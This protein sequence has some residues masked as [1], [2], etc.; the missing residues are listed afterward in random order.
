[1]KE[2][3]TTGIWQT[4]QA[5]DLI[6]KYYR[7][8]IQVYHPKSNKIETFTTTEPYS[9][10]LSTNSK[11]SHIIDLSIPENMPVG[12]HQQKDVKVAAPED[13]IFYETHI[14]DFSAHDKA[15]ISEKN[16]DK[17]LAFTEQNSD[18]INHLKALKNAGINNIHL[19]PSFD[20]ATVNENES[21]VLDIN[22]PLGKLC[23]QLPTLS[24]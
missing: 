15:F 7:Y 1:M 19:L 14:R 3:L 17:Y 18:G 5:T 8:Q 9:L 11:Y 24:L 16:R 12:W 10:N 13:N 23:H 4:N 21:S 2:D 22:D 20:I 6:G